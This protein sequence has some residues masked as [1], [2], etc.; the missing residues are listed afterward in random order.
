[1]ISS[2]SLSLRPTSMQSHSSDEKKME[3]LIN[4]VEPSIILRGNPHEA[5]GTFLRGQLMLNLSKP[6]NI[7]KIEI[8]FIGKAKT[9]WVAGLK[10]EQQAHTEKHET[11]NRKVQFVI[12][13][14]TAEEPSQHGKFGLKN[15]SVKFK[16][17]N[18]VSAGSYVEHGSIR[19]K[20]IAEVSRSMLLPKLVKKYDLKIVRILPD[21]EISE[22]IALLR[23]YDS[24]LRY[25]ISIPKRAYSLGQTVPIEVKLIPLIKNL[26]IRGLLVELLEEI[27]YTANGAQAGTTKVVTTHN[28]D[29]LVHEN[30]LQD[31]DDI[32][33]ISYHET[34]RFFIPNETNYS[35]NTPL[36]NISHN[37][38]IYFI[39][40][41]PHDPD[42]NSKTK[43][44]VRCPIT[45]ISCVEAGQ[46]FDLPN[47]EEKFC[48][49]DPEYERVARLVLGEAA[50]EGC[51][52]G[53][54]NTEPET[55]VTGC[56]N[57]GNY[58]NC[59]NCGNCENCD[60][61]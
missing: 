25:E 1:M 31:Q 46:F 33:D 10:N 59:E 3:L 9:F 47:Y 15:L 35:M 29:N 53:G 55:S 34:L 41:F 22:G 61:Q 40:N 51:N 45:I 12:P 39:V 7:R 20:L 48:T 32:E 56:G 42:D 5:P 17:P 19:Y 49:C 14:P 27:T 18:M 11:I 8:K 52:C 54:R 13:P 43:L 50:T 6:T 26:K 30:L 4:L 23:D 28:S 44:F 2:S 58:R 37:F 21:Y 16:D 57:C 60:L 24:T 36:I 38:K